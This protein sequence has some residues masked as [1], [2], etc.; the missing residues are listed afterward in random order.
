MKKYLLFLYIISSNVFSQEVLI[1]QYEL[2]RNINMENILSSTETN[3]YQIPD[4]LKKE[5]E[6]KFNETQSYSLI[7]NQTESTFNWIKKISNSQNGGM[8]SGV[9]L[10][11]TGLIH[12]NFETQTFQWETSVSNKNYI[13]SDSLKKY[14]WKISNETKDILGYETRKAEATIDSLITIEAW[15]APKLAF[16]NG[17]EYYDGLPGLILE[18][19]EM[20]TSSKILQSTKKFTATSILIDK[21]KKIIKPKKGKIISKTEYEQI[22]KENRIRRSEMYGN[23][24]DK[25]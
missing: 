3:G 13:V 6:E 9:S 18:A 20:K 12:K 15:Y 11:D 14:D 10:G 5:L 8:F 1:V 25:D 24:V 22:K 16:K 4:F 21:D 7:L 23:G 2:H 19:I 17:P